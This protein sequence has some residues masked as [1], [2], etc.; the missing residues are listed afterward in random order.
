[1]RRTFRTKEPDAVERM[2][3][4]NKWM[5][6]QVKVVQK[7]TYTQL[8][9]DIINDGTAFYQWLESAKVGGLIEK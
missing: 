6:G 7:E 4:T 5:Q 2:L 1:M 3:R 9:V 8:T